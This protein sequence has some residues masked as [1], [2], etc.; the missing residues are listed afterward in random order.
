M[1]CGN[2]IPYPLRGSVAATMSKSKSAGIGHKCTINCTG[3]T[4][5]AGSA[6]ID[7]L[8][9]LGTDHLRNAK[10]TM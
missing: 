2:N 3:G 6:M 1:Y 10:A 5:A 9:A 4:F 8:S 7:V